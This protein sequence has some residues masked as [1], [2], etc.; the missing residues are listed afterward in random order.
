L[1][2]SAAETY[3]GIYEYEFPKEHVGKEHWQEWSRDYSAMERK[4]I[5]NKGIYRVDE[6]IAEFKMR[7][8]DITK[9][10]LQKTKYHYH[11]KLIV[12]WEAVM[13]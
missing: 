2:L 6:I 1:K 8:R 12:A 11:I 13:M 4:E 9:D 7:L 3:D 5:E 10:F